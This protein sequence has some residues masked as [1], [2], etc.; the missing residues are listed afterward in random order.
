MTSLHNLLSD[1]GRGH[2]RDFGSFSPP[3]PPSRVWD[4]DMDMMCRRTLTGH[5]DDV[6]HLSLISPGGGGGGGNAFP[7]ESDGGGG[8]PSRAAM[9]CSVVASASA[10]GTVRLWW[11]L[12]FRVV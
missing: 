2:G 3:L 6:T 10:D 9:A 4:K 7:S 11:V 12:L 8:A 1:V 5:T